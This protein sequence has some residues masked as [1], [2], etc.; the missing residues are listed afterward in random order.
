MVEIETT[1]IIEI[2]VIPTTVITIQTIDHETTHTTDRTITDQTTINT[3]DQE[4][5]H[6]TETLVIII[7]IEIIHNHHIE[8]ITII[9]ILNIETEAIHQNTK[10]K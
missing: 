10:D 4:T 1:R 2:E 6:K 9:T 8:T 7:D 3:I 5:I